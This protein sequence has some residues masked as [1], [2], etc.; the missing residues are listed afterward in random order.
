MRACVLQFRSIKYGAHEQMLFP[1]TTLQAGVSN[2]LFSLRCFPSP[3]KSTNP[4]RLH[5]ESKALKG[6]PPPALWHVT[7]PSGEVLPPE[8]VRKRLIR[9]KDDK[10]AWTMEL[11]ILVSKK[12]VNKLAV[13]R[14][15]CARRLRE[16]IR[17]VV[18]RGAYVKDGEI[19]FD[20][21]EEGP[22]NWLIP[23]ATVTSPSH[24]CMSS[25]SDSQTQA[26]ATWPL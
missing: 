7:H 3:R 22:R 12:R 8:A 9:S 2:E 21:A 23:G 4:P 13:V 6:T 1:K 15:R 18:A 5:E 10:K 17:L 19:A 25:H 11:T 20:Q 24:H 26:L 16:A 14:N